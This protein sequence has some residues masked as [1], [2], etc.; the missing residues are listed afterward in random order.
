MYL[1]YLRRRYLRLKIGIP[2]AMSRLKPY[3][4]DD[5]IVYIDVLGWERESKL[6]RYL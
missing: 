4:R 3:R 2:K 5:G 1:G 6:F